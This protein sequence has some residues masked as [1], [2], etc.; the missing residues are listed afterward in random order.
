M[1]I[2]DWS[3][4]VCSSDLERAADEAH[5]TDDGLGDGGDRVEQAVLR[6]DDLREPERHEHPAHRRDHRGQGESE[7]LGESHIYADRSGGSLVVPPGEQA[8]PSWAAS[9]VG[10]EP[11][12][13]HRA[14]EGDE[15]LARGASDRKSTQLK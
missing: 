2:S 7:E 14:S 9:A 4:D 1:R 12:N 6:E 5:P 8:T 11:L 3:S 10:A 13:R 15:G